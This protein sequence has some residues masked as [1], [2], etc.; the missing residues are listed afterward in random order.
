MDE[1]G[2]ISAHIDG[3]IRSDY[4]ANSFLMMPLS[5]EDPSSPR[6]HFTHTF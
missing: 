6:N 1:S 5:S 2:R 4:R 3:L